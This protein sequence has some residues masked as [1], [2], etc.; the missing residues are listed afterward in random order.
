MGSV[1]KPPGDIYDSPMG[2]RLAIGDG[3]IGWCAPLGKPAIGDGCN[4]LNEPI[5][6]FNK[7][8]EPVSGA[9]QPITPVPNGW[10][11]PSS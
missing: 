7:P 3:V 2:T 4:W 8:I 1:G 10:N 5:L 9:H 11:E 6:T